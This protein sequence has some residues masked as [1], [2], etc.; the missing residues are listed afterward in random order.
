MTPPVDSDG[1]NTCLHPVQQEER[2]GACSRS[3]LPPTPGQQSQSRPAA[4]RLQ[5]PLTWALHVF[6]A[7]TPTTG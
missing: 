6:C 3:A 1:L 4:G 7:P 5:Q 2:P